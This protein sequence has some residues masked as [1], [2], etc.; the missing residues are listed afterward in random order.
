MVAIGFAGLAL[1]AAQRKGAALASSRR[2]ARVVRRAE[3]EE[4]V[5]IL[6]ALSAEDAAE[7]AEAERLEMEF[8]V[9]ESDIDGSFQEEEKTE[10]ELAREGKR[11]RTY[12]LY[13]APQYVTMIAKENAVRQ[14]T[15]DGPDGKKFD[16]LQVQIAVLTERIRAAVRNLQAKPRHGDVQTNLIVMVTRRRKL[17]D[18]LSWTD[19]EAYKRIRD[20]LKI[21]HVYRMEALI[22]RLPAYVHND[23]DR[24][25]A[26]GTSAIMR[27]KKQRALVE[28]RLTRMASQENVDPARLAKM[29][30]QYTGMK[31]QPSDVDQMKYLVF[32]R[33]SPA[34]Y[35]DQTKLPPKINKTNV[36]NWKP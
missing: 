4:G 26:P 24:Q 33:G 17:L 22:G 6:G 31:F 9:D 3:D 25:K 35:L 1:H 34:N 15:E 20:A 29:R 23:R 11:T 13:P 32:G 14:W 10:E 36:L 27:I 18:T 16:T 28:R 21:R 8:A 7:E 19:I 2:P 30:K 5:S 12:D